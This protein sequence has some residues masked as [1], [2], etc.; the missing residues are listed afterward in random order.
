[1][2]SGQSQQSR[3]TPPAGA[4]ATA[5]AHDTV[6][7]PVGD[8]YAVLEVSQHASPF[9]IEQAFD[10]KIWDLVIAAQ[11]D[12]IDGEAFHRVCLVHPRR[13]RTRFGVGF[14]T[15]LTFRCPLPMTRFT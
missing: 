15:K 9:E 10:G 11:G 4:P 14:E 3:P 7:P 12:E 2:I 6:N 8:H 5:G 1:M 13:E